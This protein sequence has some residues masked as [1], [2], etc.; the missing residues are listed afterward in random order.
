SEDE[1]SKEDRDKSDD[2]DSENNN[3]EQGNKRCNFTNLILK[4]TKLVD[5]DPEEVQEAEK[6]LEE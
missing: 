6:D 1:A 3:T 5:L 2:N 4:I